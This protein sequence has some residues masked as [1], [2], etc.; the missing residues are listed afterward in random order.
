MFAFSAALAALLVSTVTA[1]PHIIRQSTGPSATRSCLSLRDGSCNATNIDKSNIWNNTDCVLYAVCT[2]PTENPSYVPIEYGA[3]TNQPRLTESTFKILSGGKDTMTQQAFIDAYYGAISNIPNG[4]YPDSSADVI[5]EW[6][7]VAA[8]TGDCST[9]EIPYSNFADWLEYS[10]N[11][12]VCPAVSNCDASKAVGPA[13]QCVPQPSTDNGSCAEIKNQCQLWVTG[14]LFQNLYCVLASMCYAESTTDILIAQEYPSYVSNI[15]TSASEAR[16]SYDVFSN[17][18]KGASTMS[19]QNVI[20]AYYG[21]LTGT[22]ISTGGPFG[23]ESPEKTSNNGPYP[24]S[25][26]YVSNFWSIIAAW[27]GYCDTKEIPYSNLADYLNHAATS[28]Y[29][30]TC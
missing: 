5:Q 15:P 4:T 19:E 16:L 25:T 26:A 22:W 7:N 3:S 30:P 1:T 2:Y 24:T 20:D 23:A 6:A 27:T 18:T 11:A 10:S 13:E 29:H 17:I 28:N 9:M 14:G 8:W 12:G 21:A